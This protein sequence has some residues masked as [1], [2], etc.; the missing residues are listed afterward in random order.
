MRK[1]MKE[2]RQTPAGKKLE[3]IRSWKK[4]GMIHDNYDQLYEDYLACF[5]CEICE[6]NFKSTL[7]RHMDHDHDTG[8]FRWFL[9]CSCNNKDYWKK[10]LLEKITNPQVL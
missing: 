3:T 7:D 2:H 5:R 1:Y 4:Y 9:C 10:V 6:K 8:K